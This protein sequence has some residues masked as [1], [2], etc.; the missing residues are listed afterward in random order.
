MDSPRRVKA[1][2]ITS[3]FL[4]TELSEERRLLTDAIN[5]RVPSEFRSI[6]NSFERFGFRAGFAVAAVTQC[7]SR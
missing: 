4:M 7:A 2:D 5:Y 3:L 1:L 6:G